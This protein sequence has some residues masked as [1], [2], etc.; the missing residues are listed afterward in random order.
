MNNSTKRQPNVDV[1]QLITE[2]PGP[3]IS[4]DEIIDQ[5]S[6]PEPDSILRQMLR[7]DETKG[8]PDERDI[9]G[10]SDLYDTPHGSEER[11]N[12]IKRGLDTE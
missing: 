9:A 5:A 8:D 6:R 3:H 7:G 11:K 4:V 2:D 10:A 12:E 1:D